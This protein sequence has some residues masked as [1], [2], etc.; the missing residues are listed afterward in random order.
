M[1]QIYLKIYIY[2]QYFNYKCLGD[3]VSVA[4]F[5][6]YSKPSKYSYHWHE[7][8][9]W[10]LSVNGFDVSLSVRMC[11]SNKIRAYSIYS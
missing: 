6:C 8:Q 3:Y 5:M 11:F 2:S 1:L 7:K 9:F 4:K 10:R